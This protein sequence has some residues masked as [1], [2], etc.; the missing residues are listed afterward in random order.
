MSL[1]FVVTRIA[2]VHFRTTESVPISTTT[3]LIIW[4]SPLG[5]VKTIIPLAVT[6]HKPTAILSCSCKN[7]IQRNIKFYFM[8]NKKLVAA[9]NEKDIKL[10]LYI[11]LSIIAPCVCHALSFG[12][13]IVVM[14]IFTMDLNKWASQDE[15]M[16]W[17][18]T[19]HNLN[20]LAVHVDVCC[21][22]KRCKKNSRKFE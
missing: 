20:H 17:S 18:Y 7:R 10:W 14:L 11:M 13:W 3:V 6:V 12:E 9:K 15:L 22:K 21:E 16:W 5:T 8:V 19:L 2:T 4:I 1:E